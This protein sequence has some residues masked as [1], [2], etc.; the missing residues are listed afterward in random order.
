MLK[1]C[2]LCVLVCA[3]VVGGVRAMALDP[4]Q[5]NQVMI[6]FYA[7]QN[8][9]FNLMF[10]NGGI[11]FEDYVLLLRTNLIPLESE[12]LLSTPDKD[13]LTRINAAFD[14]LE[15]AVRG[16]AIAQEPLNKLFAED[17]SSSYSGVYAKLIEIDNMGVT[18][19]F[20]AVTATSGGSAGFK[21]LIANG[22][23]LAAFGD[24]SY[25][26]FWRIEKD[27]PFVT[28]DM[29]ALVDSLHLYGM[30]GTIPVRLFNM[31][32]A[33]DKQVVITKANIAEEVRIKGNGLCCNSARKCQPLTGYNCP[34]CNQTTQACCLGA[35]SCPPS[36]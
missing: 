32:Q 4:T 5:P 20:L 34:V 16:S 26:D 6:D 13:L 24:L 10:G 25:P 7:H 21:T 12:S 11:K 28:K 19:P 14:A 8:I 3:V 35:Q 18:F 1:K 30:F 36:Q 33:Q 2:V 27:D 17:M 22:T 31:D 9:T 23:L 29:I 15:S